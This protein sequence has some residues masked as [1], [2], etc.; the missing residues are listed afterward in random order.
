[1]STILNATCIALLDAG[2]PMKTLVGAATCAVLPDR[3]LLLDPTEEEE[4]VSTVLSIRSYGYY[5][6][7]SSAVFMFAFTPLFDGLL[8]CRTQGTTTEDEYFE[9]L[10][11]AEQACNTTFRVMR[12]AITHHYTP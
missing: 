7:S 1:M 10:K 2:V 3:T 6:Q 9:C 11:S 12:E 4:K 5:D 8:A